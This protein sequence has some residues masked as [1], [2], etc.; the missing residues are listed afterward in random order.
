MHEIPG[1]NILVQLQTNSICL[2]TAWPPPCSSLS[3][4]AIDQNLDLRPKNPQ[5]MNMPVKVQTNSGAELDLCLEL[6]CN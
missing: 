2:A 1:M 3:S 5:I 6:Q 4:N